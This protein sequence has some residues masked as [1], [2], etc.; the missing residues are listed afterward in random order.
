V[1]VSHSDLVERRVLAIDGGGSKTDVVLVN[2]HGELLAEVQGPSSQPHSYGLPQALA[3][4]DDLVEQVRRA[5]GLPAGEP[6]AEHAAVYLSGLDLPEELAAI[7][8]ALRLRGWAESLVVDNDIFAVLRAGTQALDAVAVVCGSGINCAGRN[9][10]GQQSRF[11]A[12]GAMS[13]D[14]GG[15]HHL[16]E[17]ALWHATRADDGRGRPTVLQT[18][19]AS[20]FGL[21]DALSVGAAMHLGRI[22]QDRLNELPRVVFA[23]A[24]GGDEIA[25]RLVD[26]LAGEMALLAAVSMRRLDLLDRPVDLVLGGGVARSRD[27]RLL[28]VLTREVLATNPL[29]RVIVVDAAPVLGAALLGLDA[30]GAAPGE[31]FPSRRSEPCQLP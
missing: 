13:G 24:A 9:A 6:L 11:A 17:R 10:L 30:I 14:W 22:S 4:L 25:V 5:A 3:V 31:N 28:D 18:A 8:P 19:I 27:P 1:G 26:R 20:Y 7:E 15:G 2:G 23:A 16:G 21:P 12:L 29:T